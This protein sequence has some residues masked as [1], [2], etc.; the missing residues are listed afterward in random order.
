MGKDA[1][2]KPFLEAAE[3]ELKP[4]KEQQKKARPLPARLQAAANRLARYTASEAEIICRVDER[5]GQFAKAQ[6]E[7]AEVRVKKAEAQEEHKA[8]AESAAVG[9]SVTMVGQAA[10][11]MAGLLGAQG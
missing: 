11:F 7:L 10:D 4:L 6:E 1:W 2:I 5:Q 9:T 8:V 3:V